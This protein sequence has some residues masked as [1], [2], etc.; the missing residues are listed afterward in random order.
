[1]PTNSNITQTPLEKA[2][3]KM[4]QMRAD[5]WRPIQLN[6]IDKA[7]KNPNSLKLAIRAMCWTC[8]GKDN[9]PGVKQRVSLCSISSCPLWLHRPWQSIKDHASESALDLDSN[10]DLEEE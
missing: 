7:K 4:K 2:H 10:P 5:G 6:P 3:E 9:D 1:M 8:E